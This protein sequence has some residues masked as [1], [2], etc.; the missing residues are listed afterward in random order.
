M[1]WKSTHTFRVRQI[2]GTYPLLQIGGID[3]VGGGRMIPTTLA[4]QVAATLARWFGIPDAD[5]DIVAPHID[6]F[7]QRDLGIMV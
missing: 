5:L 2:Y 3:D 7:L 1:L 4:D 6:N